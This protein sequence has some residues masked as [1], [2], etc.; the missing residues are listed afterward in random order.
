MLRVII[1][2]DG[3]ISHAHLRDSVDDRL[4]FRLSQRATII[5]E[6]ERLPATKSKPISINRPGFCNPSAA[7]LDGLRWSNNLQGFPP[8]RRPDRAIGLGSLHHRERGKN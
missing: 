5:Q 6:R 3:I 1:A 4:P 2:I 7:K 8:G